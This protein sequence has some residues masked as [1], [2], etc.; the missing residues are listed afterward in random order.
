MIIIFLFSFFASN[1]VIKKKI[2]MTQVW[3]IIAEGSTILIEEAAT[4]TANIF[5]QDYINFGE[6][7][8]RQDLLCQLYL[9]T[10]CFKHY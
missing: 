7:H 3:K 5:M 8:P 9:Q 1:F 10:K 2:F 6:L 4:T